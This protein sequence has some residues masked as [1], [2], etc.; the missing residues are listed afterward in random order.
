VTTRGILI[1]LV[2]LTTCACTVGPNYKRPVVTVPDAYRGATPVE[3]LVPDSVSFGHQK[4]WDVFED[5]ELRT[6]IAT[7][8]RQNLDV[9]VAAT[10]VLEAQAQLGIV[11]ADQFP[12]VDASAGLSNV[13]LAQALGFPSIETNLVN[14]QASASWEVDFW[15]KFRRATEA[16]RARL[17]ASEWGGRAVITTLVSQVA[18]AYFQLRALDLQLE[19][20]K[21]TL[22]SR[23]E[24]LRLTEVRAQ[25]GVTSLLDVRQ[26]EQ[27]VY[28]A[29]AVIVDLERQIV[30][31]ENFISTLLGTNPAGVLRGGR[32]LLDQPHPPDVPAGL[33]STLLERRPDIAQ[34]EQLLIAANADIGVAK[35]AY[36]PQISLTGT[37]GF[38]SA[39]LSSLFTGP[40]GMWSVGAALVQPVFTAGRTRAGVDLAR[41]RTDEATLVYQQ[42]IQ[43][44]LRE[45]SDALVAYRRG[46]EFREQLELLDRTAADARRLAEVRYQGGATSYLEVLDSDTRLFVADLSVAQAQLTELLAFVQIYRSLGGGWEQ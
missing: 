45:V 33:P 28:G 18:G 19:I 16:A 4:W 2:T 11:R 26:A 31:Q 32:S 10:R 12:N 1:F 14:V 17:L 21:R 25:G 39:A 37:G 36:F 9:R 23:G 41:A 34:A 15:G 38:E 27:L 20:A 7:A 30:Q 5:E 46:R 22:D 3:S 6:L 35:A 44:S 8:L 13:R 42:T 40:G 29:A 24:S 43:Q